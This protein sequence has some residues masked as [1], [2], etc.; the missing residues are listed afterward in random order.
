MKLLRTIIK[1]KEIDNTMDF[2][3]N[4]A[5]FIDKPFLVTAET[6]KKG[7]GQ[8]NKRWESQKGGLWITLCFD[9]KEP[10]GISTYI[11]IP[12]L[13]TIK[14]F[15]EDKNIGIKWPNDIFLEGK[16][17]AGILVELKNYTAFVGIGINVENKIPKDLSD[18]A[19]SMSEFSQVKLNSI[20]NALLKNI[21][22]TIGTFL[23]S[24]FSVFKKEYKENLMLLGKKVEIQ[25]DK[26]TISGTVKDIGDNGELILTAEGKDMQIV[27][28]SIVKFN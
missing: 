14:A 25:K 24:G 7:R 9:V 26:K 13:R 17:V 16:K 27:Y 18:I 15:L 11:S 6:Q 22:D 2:A 1:V 23:N 10:L 8:H 5:P 3:K 21:E 28:G 20:L 12:V 19:V 4:L